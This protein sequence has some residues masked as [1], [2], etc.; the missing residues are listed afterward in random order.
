MQ[1]KLYFMCMELNDTF[2][3]NGRIRCG[4]VFRVNFTGNIPGAKGHRSK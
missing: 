1:V 2:L 3:P 4:S